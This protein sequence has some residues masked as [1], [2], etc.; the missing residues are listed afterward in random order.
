MYVYLGLIVIVIRV[1]FRM[2]LDGQYGAH[3]LFTLP[4][5]PLPDAAAGIRLGGPVSLEGILAAFYDGLRLATLLLCIGSANLLANPKRLLKSMPGA[6]HEM[7]VAVTVALTFAPQIIES[8]HRVRRARRLR[9][10]SSHRRQVIRT[11][12]VPVLTDALDRSLALAA[13]MD[14][15]GYGRRADVPARARATSGALLLGGLVGAC[16]GTYGMLDSTVPRALGVPLLAVGIAAAVAGL[17]LAGRRIRRTVYRPDPWAL[18]EWA[19]SACGIAAAI[20]LVVVGNVDPADL[21]PS[22]SPLTWPTLPLAPVIGILIGVLPA[23]LAPPVQHAGSG[24]A[25][26][27]PRSEPRPPS[28]P[29]DEPVQVAG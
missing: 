27:V 29:A 16:V 12:V 24:G 25:R 8:G 2:L 13:A 5:V 23:W 14:T 6:L 17:T 11:I 26:T 21:H 22:L 15:R 1:V 19:V 20:T 28:V 18:D 7:G 9:G 10:G 4:E 3:I